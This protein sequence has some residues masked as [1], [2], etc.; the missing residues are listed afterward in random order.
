MRALVIDDSRAVRII[1][2]NLRCL[3]GNTLRKPTPIVSRTAGPDA[4]GK[5]MLTVLVALAD[6]ADQ[7]GGIG[8]RRAGQ[9]AQM[10]EQG[11]GATKHGGTPRGR[12]GA[13]STL[14]YLPARPP[15]RTLF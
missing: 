3:P 9:P 6:P 5:R 10:S 2:G 13:T 15:L 8:L 4:R 12:G 14:H 11:G 7:Q 1:I